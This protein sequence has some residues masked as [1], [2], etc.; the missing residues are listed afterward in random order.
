MVQKIP[1]PQIYG[2]A[3]GCPLVASNQE[4]KRN[5]ARRASPRYS[6]S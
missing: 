4:L 2:T 6:G 3:H 5:G 1:Y